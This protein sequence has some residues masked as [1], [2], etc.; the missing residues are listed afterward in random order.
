MQ[1]KYQTTELRELRD[2][3]TRFSPREKKLTQS[4]Q[5][6]IL[7]R[8]LDPARRDYSYEYLFFRVTGFRP[9]TTESPHAD[10]RC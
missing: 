4:G 9:G 3:L 6:E 1:G 7:L 2:Q 8:E 10:L 5:A